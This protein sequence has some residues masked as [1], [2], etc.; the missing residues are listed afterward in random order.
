MKKELKD[1]TDADYSI[2]PIVIPSANLA[3][4]PMLADAL[5]SFP[6]FHDTFMNDMYRKVTAEWDAKLKAYIEENLKQ[7]GYTFENEAEFFEFCKNR[8]HR[9]AFTENPNYYEF[10]LDFVDADDKGI[11]VGSCSDKMDFKMDGNTATV[12]IGKSIG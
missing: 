7:F 8:V 12:T 11:F 4:N 1:G 10:Y 6:N 2:Q 9:L 3:A 5:G